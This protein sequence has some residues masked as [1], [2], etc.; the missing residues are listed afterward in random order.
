MAVEDFGRPR[1]RNGSD[2]F[3]GG[4]PPTPGSTGYRRPAFRAALVMTPKQRRT[5]SSGRSGVRRRPRG[6]ER[7][8]DKQR[9]DDTHS[10]RFGEFRRQVCQSLFDPMGAT[11]TRLAVPGPRQGGWSSAEETGL[12]FS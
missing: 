11:R 6:A 2:A 8:K 7:R 9:I 4:F 1:A 3:N 5:S 10:N 12:V